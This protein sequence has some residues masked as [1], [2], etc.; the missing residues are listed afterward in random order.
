MTTTTAISFQGEALLLDPAGVLVWPRRSLIAVADLHFEK[1][2]ACAARG[3]LLPPWD[4]RQ[5]LQRL[6]DVLDR[7]RPATV[8]ALGDSFHDGRGAA[9][10][11]SEDAVLLA[12]M[13]GACRF[14]WIRGNHDPAPPRGL[15]GLAAKDWQ[16][17]GLAFRHQA[18][19]DGRGEVSGHFHPKARIATRA[20]HIVRPCFVGDANRLILP[21]FGAYTGGL[22]IASPAIARLFP[23]GCRA[24]VL[25]TGRLFGFSLVAA[26]PQP[27][28]LTL[29]GAASQHNF[30]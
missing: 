29:A 5:T 18:D 26:H 28:H 11:A 27:K 12:A 3:Q 24:H 10:L 14:V 15:P 20:G 13:A 6:A 9:R 19:P 17:D 21:A 1:G 30:P 25:G 22:D 16:E 7:Y 23:E 4:T 2:S 8:L